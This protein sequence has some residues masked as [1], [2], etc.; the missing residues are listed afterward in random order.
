[1]LRF[2]SSLARDGIHPL[3]GVLLAVIILAGLWLWT[4][5]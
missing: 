4:Q 5:G 3:L 1:M 2:L